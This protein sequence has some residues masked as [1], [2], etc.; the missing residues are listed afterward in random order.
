MAKVITFEQ[1]NA[2]A[3][4]IDIGA[5]KI[6]VSPDGIQ[7]FVYQTFTSDYRRCVADMLS[8]GIK[9]VCM[10]ATGVYWIALYELP[11]SAGLPAFFAGDPPTPTL[12][13]SIKN[14]PP[15]KQ[16]RINTPIKT[17]TKNPLPHQP[18][19]TKKIRQKPHTKH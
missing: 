4:A 8:W 11:S 3:A 9:R 18:Q 2:H 13:S 5:E 10:E 14:L 7:V 12:E 1:V 16:K 15:T 19:I 17:T 6:F